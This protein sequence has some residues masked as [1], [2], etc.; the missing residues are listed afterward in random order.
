MI[1]LLG[2][3][4]FKKELLHEILKSIETENSILNYRDRQHFIIQI[5]L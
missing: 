3:F 5:N 1:V 4:S 2:S